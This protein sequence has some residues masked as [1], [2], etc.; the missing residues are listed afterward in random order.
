MC[1]Y[2][3]VIVS[4]RTAPDMFYVPQLA[5]RQD[6]DEWLV[7]D[8]ARDSSRPEANWCGMCCAKMAAEANGFTT[9]SL[10]EMYR[11]ACELGV[12]KPGQESKG[13]HH[14]ELAAYMQGVLQIPAEARR[15]LTTRSVL[16]WLDRRY[17]VIASVHQSIR[18][19]EAPAPERK[20][21]HLIFVYGYEFGR[22]GTSLLLNN[23]TGLHATDT[24]IGVRVKLERFEQFFS[25]RGILVK[26]VS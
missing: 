13:A 15:D 22:D 14:R 2:D 24:Q 26:K 12:Y 6:V 25:G 16:T 7:S 10:L 11:Q 19:P 17:F 9:P 23:S 3:G 8:E 5:D 1:D 20:S 18:D 4:G 21:G